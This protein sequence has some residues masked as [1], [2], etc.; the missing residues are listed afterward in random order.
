MSTTF[1]DVNASITDCT[2]LNADGEAC[3]KPGSPRLPLGVCLQ[4]TI[5]ITRAALRLGGDLTQLAKEET[6]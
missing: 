2:V 3:G 6:R 4:H 5:E 1:G